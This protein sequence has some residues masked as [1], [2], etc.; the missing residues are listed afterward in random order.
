VKR[1]RPTLARGA[2]ALALSAA[3]AALALSL[4][5]S[6]LFLPLLLVAL[7]VLAA[8]TLE[9]SAAPAGAT[10]TLP[11]VFAP[12]AFVVAAL[13]WL[14]RSLGSL[15][16]EPSLLPRL[17]APLFVSVA[18]VFLL[19]PPRLVPAWGLPA[20]IVSVLALA[21]LNPAPA[22]YGG[23]RLAFLAG[24]DRNG[25]AEVYLVGVVVVAGALWTAA[26]AGTGPRWSLRMVATIV[27][28]VVLAVALAAS[29]VVG[30]PVA[31]PYVEKTVVDALGGGTTGLSGE[32][33]LGEIGALSLSRRR[34]LDLQ[35]SRREGGSWRLASEVFTRFDGRSWTNDTPPGRTV[36]ILR[37]EPPPAHGRL[38]SHLGSWF[39]GPERD[40]EPPGPEAEEL[41]I[42]QAAVDDWPLL[43]PRRVR[44][45][46][47]RASLLNLDRFDLVRRPQGLPLAQYGAIVAG[48]PPLDRATSPGL[49]AEERAESL[50]L[51]QSVDARVRALAARLGARAASPRE[52]L[53]LTVGHL[54]TGYRYT[55]EPGPFRP[56]GDPLAEFLFEKKAAYCEYFASA[57]V[58]LLRLQGVPARFVKGLSVGPQTDMGGGLHVVRESDAHAW[59]EAWMPGEGWVEADP[60]PPGQFAAARPAPS[61]LHRWAE[62]LRAGVAGAWARL[63]EAGPL[64]F[65]R[66]LGGEIVDLAGRAYRQPVL[67]LVVV[68][69]VLVTVAWRRLR[70]SLRRRRSERAED[71]TRHVPAGLR[72]LV[73]DLER[74]WRDY[75]RPR[76]P[77][78]GL[79]EHASALAEPAP[80]G[81][82]PLPPSLV[83]AGRDIVHAY[84]A[85][86]FGEGAPPAPED[87]RRLRARF[88]A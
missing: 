29:G 79:L 10:R 32:S 53:A 8:P 47:A 77:T 73:R 60:T 88:D 30:L 15:V 34:V 12:A 3:V 56:G 82:T 18:V 16:L 83:E 48:T 71:V 21:G 6:A 38:L 23:T 45:V 67:R 52:R 13:A 14:S 19:A 68:L 76:P 31:Q 46:T 54:Q 17:G 11:R 86:R 25:F 4:R 41:R 26:F 1:V 75:D 85:A 50:S 61:R 44:S 39:P 33:R 70:R 80:R 74:R 24:V 72:A 62:H 65:V 35:S 59:V 5:E 63:V 22:G 57:A 78:R 64:S 40:P 66:W 42:T 9:W 37:P 55:L 2:Q 49:S 87:L 28:T 81:A 20:T 43:L 36:D 7:L 58:V 84:Y 69:A 27:T 51:P